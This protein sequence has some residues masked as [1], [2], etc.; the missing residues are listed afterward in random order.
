VRRASSRRPRSR[1]RD[2]PKQ[3]HDPQ[4]SDERKEKRGA[5]RQVRVSDLTEPG[6]CPCNWGGFVVGFSV[7][8]VHLNVRSHGAWEVVEGK[9]LRQHEVLV[10][11]MLSRE[12]K[13]LVAS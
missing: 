9:E 7:Q 3:S 6:L 10:F 8:E 12:E 4:E 11:G 13:H 2:P 5:G 1:E